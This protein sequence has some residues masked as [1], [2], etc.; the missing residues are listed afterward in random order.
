MRL[1]F[2]PEAVSELQFA[3][4]YYEGC[5]PGLGQRFVDAVEEA[6]RRISDAPFACRL[7]E[8]EVRRCLTRV[9]PYGVMYTV[10]ADSILIVAVC[11]CAREP[12]Y[13][14]RRL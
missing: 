10:A 3:A 14:K 5:R 7:L 1:E 12:G 8:H 9:F 13:W 2:H 6:I 11:H 4:R